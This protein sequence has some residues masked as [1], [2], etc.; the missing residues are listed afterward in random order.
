MKYVT[1]RI[2]SLNAFYSSIRCIAECLLKRKA[3]CHSIG[4]V[5]YFLQMPNGFHQVGS[6]TF[7]SSGSV[8]LLHSRWCS[9]PSVAQCLHIFSFNWSSRLPGNFS[10]IVV[11]DMKYATWL[12]VI[13]CHSG[14]KWK[15]F[16]AL[17]EFQSG[18]KL[19]CYS[20]LDYYHFVTHWTF[21]NSTLTTFWTCIEELFNGTLLSW[22]TIALMKLSTSV[23]WHFEHVMPKSGTVEFKVNPC[24]SWPHICSSE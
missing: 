13:K 5:R 6:Y 23:Y 20:I 4:T 24:L 18:T 11:S 9:M 17:V 16:W 21:S 14:R 12:I 15:M 19:N 3:C 22:R 7:G 1:L 10:L 2:L 8:D